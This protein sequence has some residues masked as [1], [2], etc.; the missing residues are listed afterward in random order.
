MI[1]FK[2]CMAVLLGGGVG[3]LSRFGLSRWIQ[4]ISHHKH[5]P[6]GVFVCNVLGCLLIGIVAGILIHR[7]EMGP[8]WRAAILIGFLGGFTTFSSFSIDT[9]TLIQQGDIMS[10]LSNVFLTVI[11]C[12]IATAG[13]LYITKSLMGH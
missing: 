1:I 11:L 12:L 2:E 5:Y 13:G 8:F 4:S 3:S 7:M 10:A 6:W 9:I